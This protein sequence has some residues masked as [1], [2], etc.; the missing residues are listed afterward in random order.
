MKFLTD[1]SDSSVAMMVCFAE[2]SELAVLT[3]TRQRICFQCIIYKWEAN[4][5]K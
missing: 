4:V 3:V 1:T 5:P 2:V